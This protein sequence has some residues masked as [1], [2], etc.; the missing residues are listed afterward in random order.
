MGEGWTTYRE[1]GEGWTT[2]SEMGEGW[3]AHREMGEGWTTHREMGEGW[4]THGEM[5]EGWTTHRE[6]RGGGQ[7]I[8]RGDGVDW[9]NYRVDTAQPEIIYIKYSL[10]QLEVKVHLYLHS[11][12]FLLYIILAEGPGVARVRKIKIKKI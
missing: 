12:I 11:V 2:Y 1:M 9:D 6:R 5:G 3:T 4:T 7:I 10:F 8:E